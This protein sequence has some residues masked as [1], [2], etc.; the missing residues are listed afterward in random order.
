MLPA[1]PHDAGVR[2]SPTRTPHLRAHAPRENASPFKRELG[3]AP[4][5][6]STSHAARSAF[7]DKTNASP[8]PARGTAPSPSKRSVASPIKGAPVP[9]TAMKS[10]FARHNSFVTPAANIGRAGQIKARLGELHDAARTPA[11]Q[12]AHTEPTQDV[13]EDELYPE[14]E[15]MPTSHAAPYVFPAQ[16]DG[17]PRAADAARLLAHAPLPAPAAPAP[18]TEI[19]IAPLPALRRTTPHRTPTPRSKAPVPARRRTQPAAPAGDALAR[20][21]AAYL[22]HNDRSDGFVL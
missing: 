3:K 13:S 9:S 22:Y 21:A 18:P 2:A 10:A 5:A 20:H 8:S 19:D 14:I 6:P 16:L 15:S 17:L 12:P 4:S 11:A 1:R 7:S